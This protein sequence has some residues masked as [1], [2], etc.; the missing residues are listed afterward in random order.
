MHGQ[1]V[2]PALDIK[3]FATGVVK[4]GNHIMCM[5]MHTIL[6]RAYLYTRAEAGFSEV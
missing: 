6:L 2:K 3:M 4:V 1:I 5:Y